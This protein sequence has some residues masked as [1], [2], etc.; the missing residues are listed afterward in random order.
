MK[1]TNGKTSTKKCGVASSHLTSQS[2]R[3]SCGSSL[4]STRTDERRRRTWRRHLPFERCPNPF[5][6][7]L[8]SPHPA[9]SRAASRFRVKRVSL[10]RGGVRG[11]NGRPA[12]RPA[13]L[14][15][16]ATASA[17]SGENSARTNGN[18]PRSRKPPA[19]STTTPPRMARVSG[20]LAR[21]IPELVAEDRRLLDE[22]C[23]LQ[24]APPAGHLHA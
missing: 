19:V 5:T 3:L 13:D 2:Q 11:G 24:P 4:P 1:A 18:S 15:P 20:R 9:H 10:R 23:T 12:T 16:G 21:G 6:R 22:P 8:P 14:L 17:R 7:S